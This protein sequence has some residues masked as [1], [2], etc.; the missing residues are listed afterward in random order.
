MTNRLSKCG[1]T[2]PPGQEVGLLD[3][4][5]PSLDWTPVLTDPDET[6]DTKSYIEEWC[7]RSRNIFGSLRFSLP[8]GSPS[9]ALNGCGALVCGTCRCCAAPPNCQLIIVQ[10]L[11]ASARCLTETAYLLTENL[12]HYA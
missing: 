12:R 5:D 11:V 6:G 8:L 10:P 2:E 9:C 4:L 1:V 3:Y 7:W